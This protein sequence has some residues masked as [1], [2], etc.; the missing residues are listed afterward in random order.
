VSANSTPTAK[1]ILQARGIRLA[2]SAPPMDV[3]IYEGEIVGLAGLEG[4]GQQRFLEALCGLYAPIEGQV[5]AILPGG[6]TIR[7]NNFHK[8]AQAG[9]AYLP[10]ER[11]TQGILP[12][13]S[14]LDNFAIGTLPQKSRF[15]FINR[16]SLREQLGQFQERLSMIFASPSAPITSLS[17]GNQQKVILAR[18]MATSP[19][20]MLLN[21][22]TRGVDMSTKLTL[23]QTFREMVETEG[24][25]LVLLSTEIEEFLQLCDRTLVFRDSSLFAELD[26]AA[27]TRASVMAAMF[28]RKHE[29]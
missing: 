9:V 1:V 13:L 22:P 27:T 3:T 11:K 20:A 29:A 6:K 24:T 8:A 17:G 2:A 25:A 18:W 21:D 15:G 19:R 7:V 23:Y 12:A 4:H 5:E 16:Q 28:G 10:R 14:V 26:R